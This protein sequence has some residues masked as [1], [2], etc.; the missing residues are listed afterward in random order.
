M[1]QLQST[2]VQKVREIIKSGA[3][4]GNAIFFAKVDDV[5]EMSV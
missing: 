2:V 5:V 1:K 4:T 3:N